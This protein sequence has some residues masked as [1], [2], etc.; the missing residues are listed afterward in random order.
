MPSHVDDHAELEKEVAGEYNT[1]R[2][3]LHMLKVK[4]S[5]ARDVQ[6]ALVLSS[7]TLAQHHLDKLCR[8]GLAHKD[9]KGTYHVRSRSFG[10]L[11][12]YYRSGKWIVPRTVFFV[13]I[14]S[15]ISASFLLSINQ[16]AAFLVAAVFSLAGL[17]FAVYETIMFY[18][19]LP[20]T[21]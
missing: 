6:Q 15:F 4:E 21:T 10:I 5:S 12:L 9:Y 20:K 7:P 11:K 1:L 8:Y 19:V 14:F 17:V 2:V 18:K 3:Y 13:I 16:G